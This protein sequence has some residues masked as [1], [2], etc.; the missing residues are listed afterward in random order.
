MSHGQNCLYGM[1]EL[2]RV[3][4]EGLLGRMKELL[5]LAHVGRQ[6]FIQRLYWD[7]SCHAHVEHT[8][9]SSALEKCLRSIAE[10]NPWAVSRNWGVLLIFAG[11]RALLFV[12]K[13]L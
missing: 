11:I 10:R 6:A 5:I 4:T 1:K 3:L 2:H 12:V 8:S 9:K 7:S 13:G